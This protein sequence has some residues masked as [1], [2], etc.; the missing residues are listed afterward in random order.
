MTRIYF[1]RHAEPIHTWQEDAT[2]PLSDE[3]LQDS[4]KVVDALAN[5]HLDYCV[6]SPYKRSI[7]TIKECA[8]LHGLEIHIDDRFRERECGSKNTREMIMKRWLDF[9]FHEEGG[10]SLQMLQNRNM[11]GLKELLSEHS[12]ETILFGTHGSA[13]STI[14]NYYDPSYNFDSFWHMIDFMPYIICL[15]FEQTRLL[16]KEEILIVKKAYNGS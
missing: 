3:G 15:D 11:D 13:L 6:C 4:K 7:D 14:L 2:R 9:N 8:K 5:I 10:E 1:V 12:N 16:K